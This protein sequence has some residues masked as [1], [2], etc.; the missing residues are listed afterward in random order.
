MFARSGFLSRKPRSKA[1]SADLR[2]LDA[3]GSYVMSWFSQAPSMTLTGSAARRRLLDRAVE[4]RLRLRRV[5][6]DVVRDVDVRPQQVLDDVRVVREVLRRGRSGASSRTRRWARGR[7][8]PGRPCRRPP[9]SGASPR[10]PAPRRRRCRPSGT[11]VSVS[12]LAVGSTVTL[13][14][15]SLALRPFCFSQAR[16]ATSWVLPSCGVAIF[17]FAK[18]AGLLMPRSCRT[19]NSAPPLVAPAMMRT[20]LPCDCT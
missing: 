8:R 5:R 11:A 4:Q 14:P 12:A 3:I 16:S 20:S 10:A 18:S 7:A 17:L 1:S 2:R 13:P 15:C 19:T 6:V 9:G